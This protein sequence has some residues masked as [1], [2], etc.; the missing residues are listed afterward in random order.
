VNSR[1]I[2]VLAAVMASTISGEATA[3]PFCGAVGQPLAARRDTAAAVAVGEATAPA[4]LQPDGV[5]TQPFRLLQCLSGERPLA[6]GETVIARVDT[7]I[8]GTAAVF[9]DR[10]DQPAGQMAIPADE[11]QLGYLAAAPAIDQPAAA[12]LRWFARW[13]EHPDPLLAED[14]FAE[15]GAA[16]FKAVRDAADALPAAK[17]QRWVR[18]EGIP[19]QR[20][21]FYGLALGIVAA[22]DPEKRA[23]CREPLLQILS[24]PADDY[25]AGFDGILAGVLVA[26]GVAGLEQL[27]ALGLLEPAA[28]PVVKRQMLAVLRFA[29]ESLSEEIPRE[30]VARG[31]A[32]LLTS[33]VTAAEATVDLARYRWWEAVDEVA[34]LWTTLG[35]DDPLVRRA[36]AGY[37]TACSTP[38]GR[39]QR[40][41]IRRGDAERFDDAV[42]ASAL[43]L[44]RA[45]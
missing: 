28:P 11:I 12:R 15:F 19:Q 18:D 23:A 37:L 30:R 42:E 4:T 34:A 20:R 5:M 31:T 21:G 1:V 27:I 44:L 17:M 22:A 39:V 38:Q 33:P 2:V 7:A 13:L 29:W 41:T 40:E 10:L 8:R 25:R 26:D 36:V 24:E 9:F 16:A 14:A 3:C 45:P 6:P 32:R 43:P 35:D